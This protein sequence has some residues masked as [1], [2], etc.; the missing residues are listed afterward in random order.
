M[1]PQNILDEKFFDWYWL[2]VDDWYILNK[3]GRNAY[4]YMKHQ[5]NEV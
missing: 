4:E 2:K 5:V 3:Q 1:K